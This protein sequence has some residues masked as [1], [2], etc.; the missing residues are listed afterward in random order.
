MRPA[1]QT[2][3][4]ALQKFQFTHPVWG[5]TVR[6]LDDAHTLE[7]SIHAPRV[8]CDLRPML[9]WLRWRCFNSRTPCGVRQGWAKELDDFQKFQFTH[10]V[11]GATRYRINY[12]TLKQVSIHAPRVGCD[13]TILIIAR[14]IASFNSRT[15]CGVRL[16]CLVS[17]TW[18]YGFN[19]RTPCGVRLVCKKSASQLWGVS[20]HAPRV[21]CDKSKV[22]IT[23]KQPRFNSRTPCGVRLSALGYQA[24][25]SRVSIHAPRVGCDG[26][27]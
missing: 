9:R 20:I 26:T 24:I 4:D 12:N 3:I 13:I 27:P 8:G 18:T 2:E 11:W 25:E 6:L 16:R 21:G 5:A 10:P 7:V 19:S 14:D 23:R 17:D 22:T 15:P 1:L